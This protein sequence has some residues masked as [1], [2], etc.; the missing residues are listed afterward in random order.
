MRSAFNNIKEVGEEDEV[1]IDPNSLSS[2][3][4]SK[5]VEDVSADTPVEE[6]KSSVQQVEDINKTDIEEPITDSAAELQNNDQQEV[7][8]AQQETLSSSNDGEVGDR[9]SVV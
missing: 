1:V 9:K 8:E 6:S 3:K 7:G 2:N 4:A 5:E